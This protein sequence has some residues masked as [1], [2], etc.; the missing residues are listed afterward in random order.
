M[1]LEFY[2]WYLRIVSTYLFR[3]FMTIIVYCYFIETM[4]LFQ[5]T[6]L[7]NNC[8]FVLIVSVVQLWSRL[9]FY[10]LLVQQ[11]HL[12]VWIGIGIRYILCQLI[13]DQYLCEVC[14]CPSH[15]I[16]VPGR[17]KTWDF[18]EKSRR[19]FCPQDRLVYSALNHTASPS[20]VKKTEYFMIKLFDKC[21]LAKHPH[22][23]YCAKRETRFSSW[24]RRARSF[25]S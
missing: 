24:A 4:L 25:L 1:R 19:F 17:D 20:L 21:A 10:L 22:Y 5:S 14:V 7:F 8:V 11:F 18:A 13:L 3:Y 15:I 23:I 12:K 2:A 9:K 16:Y 6:C